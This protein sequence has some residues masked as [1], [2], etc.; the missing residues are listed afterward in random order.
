MSG[1]GYTRQSAGSIVSGL[2]ITAAAHN[3]E[4]NQ[5]QSAFN[6]STGHAHDG[7]TGGGAPIASLNGLASSAGYV[8]FDGAGNFSV[9]SAT[10]L[11]ALA[12]LSST[13][14]LKRTGAGAYSFANPVVLLQR[15][16]L[17]ATTSSLYNG[18][19]QQTVSGMTNSFTPQSASSK[20]VIRYY[21]CPVYVI[22][23]SSGTA[24]APRFDIKRDSS[25]LVTGTILGYSAFSAVDSN[26]SA[27]VYLTATIREYVSAIF[28]ENSPGT[29]AVTYAVKVS[30]QN[31][32]GTNFSVVQGVMVVEEWL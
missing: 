17:T 24:H 6:L 28:Q 8:K 32:V 13:G 11:D 31:N 15:A 18:N 12:V 10:E 2:V 16:V 25:T 1:T 9:K 14:Y 22:N 29:S 26:T 23:N 7:G 30:D 21:A 19:T 5:L 20:I 3:N 4:F 27:A